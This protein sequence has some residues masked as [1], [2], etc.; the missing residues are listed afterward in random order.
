M[1]KMVNF[2][3][4]VFYHNKKIGRVLAGMLG[5]RDI[6][7]SKMFLKHSLYDCNIPGTVI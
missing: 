6:K 2:M 7:E 1:V 5:E 3:L 4:C